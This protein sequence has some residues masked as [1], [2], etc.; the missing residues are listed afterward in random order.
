MSHHSSYLTEEKKLTKKF[1]LSEEEAKA[2][3]AGAERGKRSKSLDDL[4]KEEVRLLREA[5]FIDKFEDVPNKEFV[6]KDRTLKI[7]YED[8]AMREIKKIEERSD[9]DRGG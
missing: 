4:V 9:A 3:M 5:L 8:K 6:F 1:R 2:F 7:T